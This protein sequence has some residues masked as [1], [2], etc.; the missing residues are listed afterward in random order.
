MLFKTS[1][2]SSYISQGK[3]FQHNGY[4]VYLTNVSAISH[5]TQ[6]NIETLFTII[7][8]TLNEG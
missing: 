3:A 7:M 8:N 6:G 4:D 5:V 1:I 2:R